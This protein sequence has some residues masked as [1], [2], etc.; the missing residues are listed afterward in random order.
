VSC[1]STDFVFP[2]CAEVFYPIVEQGAYGDV[3]KTW[4]FDKSV[5]CN[6]SD[7]SSAMKEE[8][9][10][11]VAITQEKILVGRVKQDIRISERSSRNAITN[12]L[13]T[14]IKDQSGNQVYLE[15]SGP[16]D[17]KATLFEVASQEP[18][19]GPFGAVEYYKIVLRRS[20]N[21]AGDL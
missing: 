3:Q 10:P 7:G 2:L 18:F 15:T 14:N 1:N 11:N 12:V 16:R 13:I 6:L 21:Q 8:V 9:K 5:S 19:V 17:G 4:I 20:E